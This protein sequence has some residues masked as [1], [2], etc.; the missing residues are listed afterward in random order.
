[1]DPLQLVAVCGVLSAFDVPSLLGQNLLT[2]PGFD[3]GLGGW[4]NQG[5]AWSTL[6]AANSSFS[7]SVQLSDDPSA[8]VPQVTQCVVATPGLYDAS[9]VYRVPAGQSAGNGVFRVWTFPNA[10]CTGGFLEV[11]ELDATP[12]AFDTWVPASQGVRVPVGAQSALFQLFFQSNQA[13]ATFTGLYDNAFLAPGDSRLVLGALGRFLVKAVWE[14]PQAQTGSGH[15]Q[16]LTGDTGYFWFF[17]S[18]NVEVVVKVL[19]GCAL[20]NRFWVFAAGLTNVKVI[21]TVNDRFTGRVRTY[22]NPINTQFAPIQ[23]TAA[24][25]CS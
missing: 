25:P 23:D 17:N 10:N 3:V 6:D 2:N 1:M 7:G 24:F 12:A 15:A 11:Y 9:V 18:A 16:L 14:T 13:A 19:D 8:G 21:L 4:T 22:T 5:A 20:N